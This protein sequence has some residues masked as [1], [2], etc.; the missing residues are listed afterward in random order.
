MQTIF[1]SIKLSGNIYWALVL[2]L[3]LAMLLF[4]LCR[5]GFYLYNT[6][7][8]PDITTGGFL[9]LLLG[10]LR[11]D[12]TAV[13][14]I[15]VLI[16]LMTLIPFDF[17]FKPAYQSVIQY[18][19]F[20][21]NGA[22]IIANLADFIYY[23]FTLRRTTADVFSEFEQGPAGGVF[24]RFI[25]DYWYVTLFFLGIVWLM[26][27]LYNR[28][29]V[30]GPMMQNRVAYYSFGVLAIP[31]VA[32]LF[33]GGARGGFRHSTRPLTLSNAGEY[34]QHPRETNIVLNTPFSIFR[35]LGKT[36][37]QKANYFTDEEELE[38]FYSPVHVPSDTVPFRPD[39]VIVILLESFSKEFIGA[40]N[41]DKE[42]Y[43]GYTPFLDS[44]ILHSLT[45]EHSFSNG[46]KSI[47]GPPSVIAGIPTLGIPFVLT[48]Y[49]NNQFNS[50]A[51]LLGE[52]GY[53]TSF[54]T[55]HPNGAMGYTAFA[56]LAGINHYY[57]MDEYGNTDDY[58]GMWGIWDHKFLPYFAETI[59]EFPKPFFS[60]LFTLSSHH[61]FIVPKEFEGRFAG[62]D[63]PILKCIQ[64]TDHTLRELF[65]KISREPWYQNTL[66]VFTADHCSSDIIFDE[67]RTTWGLF[68]VPIIFFKPDNSLAGQDPGIVQHIDIMPSILGH[69][70][71]D[72]PY[73]AFGRDIFRENKKPFAFN[74]R[75]TYNLYMDNYLLSFNGE[76][77]VGLYNFVEDKMLTRNLETEKAEVVQPMEERIKAII[78]QYNNRLI[79][80]RLVAEEG[81]KTTIVQ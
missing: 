76:K 26:V 49:A 22:A 37:I 27:K 4:T 36:K 19:F 77:T 35:T 5:I 10:G 53:H 6:E 32:Y 52:K 18:M 64:Y 45:F 17:R 23:K 58:D 25:F 7:F 12:L 69:L 2:R 20:V 38:K 60:T 51:T 16:I 41:Q 31:L 15:N 39:N 55:G 56:R 79:E 28:I 24:F 54:F 81:V 34:V 78:Q 75:D 80:N 48:P 11:F 1:K 40:F 43:K 47:D 63:Q 33:V 71:F 42:N 67:S 68:S 59:N 70:H 21:L 9:R 46:R 14:Y 73:V 13:L 29:K 66:F 44:L 8:F 62:G 72:K 74:Y 30:E 3:A 65:K 50:L 61:P 57:G